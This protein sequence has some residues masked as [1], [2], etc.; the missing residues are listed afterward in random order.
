VCAPNIPSPS[1]TLEHRFCIY[2]WL[3]KCFFFFLPQFI[4]R[5]CRSGLYNILG[6]YNRTC[7]YLSPMSISWDFFFPLCL[8]LFNKYETCDTQN[9]L[10][11]VESWIIQDSHI[12]LYALPWHLVH[13]VPVYILYFYIVFSHFL[14][15][16]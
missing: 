5:T 15:G 12:A 11:R 14:L 6:I 9:F 4:N 16:I 7:M 8:A 1:R 13:E 10:G 3:F 2:S